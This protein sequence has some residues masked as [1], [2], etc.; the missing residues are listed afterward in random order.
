MDNPTSSSLTWYTYYHDPTDFT[1]VK[2]LWLA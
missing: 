2:A 1:K